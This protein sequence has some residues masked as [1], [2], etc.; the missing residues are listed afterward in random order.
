MGEYAV[1]GLRGIS[2][3]KSKV[4]FVTD[5]SN[6]YLFS[7]GKVGG[8]YQDRIYDYNYIKD[9]QIVISGKSA[10]SQLKGNKGIIV[11]AAHKPSLQN[12]KITQNSINQTLKKTDL[13]QFLKDRNKVNDC[14]VGIKFNGDSEVSHLSNIFTLGDIG[15]LFSKYT[16][17]V[18]I[19]D[20]MN[21]CGKYG[22]ANVYFRKEAVQ[23]QNVL[24]TGTQSW[25]EGLYGFYSEDSDLWNILRNNKYENVRIEQLTKE[26]NDGGKLA[27]TSIRIGKS[28][29]IANAI[30][31]NIILS[32]ASNGIYVGAT[33]SGNIFLITSIYIPTSLSKEILPSEQHS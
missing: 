17:I 9:L 20:Y 21:W 25:N 11:G 33:T 27:S 24:F 29:L 30:F 15:I 22:L 16:E 3:A 8:N 23:S 26:I 10:L 19:S 5:K 32:G 1:K 28:N 2:M 14:N 18:Y 7:M 13:Q 31:E 6:T 4:I 12:I